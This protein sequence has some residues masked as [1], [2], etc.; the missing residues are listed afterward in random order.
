MPIVCVRFIGLSVFDMPEHMSMLDDV[1]LKLENPD[2]K[3]LPIHHSNHL[4]TNEPFLS[5][6]GHLH[7]Q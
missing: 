1:G 3:N 4:K 6:K 7:F 5:K 2:C